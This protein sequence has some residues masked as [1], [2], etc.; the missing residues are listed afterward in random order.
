MLAERWIASR[1]G[2]PLGFLSTK[3]AGSLGKTR[4]DPANCWV[5][6]Q[7]PTMA[8]LRMCP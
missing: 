1:P 6:A 8:F 2:T 3:K 4:Q 5:F 7:R